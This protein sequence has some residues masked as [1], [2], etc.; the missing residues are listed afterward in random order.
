MPLYPA[1]M[2]LAAAAL[3]AILDGDRRFTR[4]V[5]GI[6]SIGFLAGLGFFVF[7]MVA[8]PLEYGDGLN[9]I[10]LLAAA[11]MSLCALYAIAS[12]WRQNIPHAVASLAAAGRHHGHHINGRYPSR[13]PF[14]LGL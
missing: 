5:G 3:V 4:W 2:M 8:V 13:G 10:S 7:V 6:G 1:L 12:L 14:S 11:V 9:P